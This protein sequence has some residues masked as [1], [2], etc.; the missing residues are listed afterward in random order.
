MGAAQP[1]LSPP[2]RRATPTP[3]M[4]SR[5]SAARRALGRAHP[6]EASGR[7]SSTRPRSCS[8]SLQD[9]RGWREGRA[10]RRRDRFCFTVGRWE[11][12]ASCGQQRLGLAEVH[13][14]SENQGQGTT[15]RGRAC[16]RI[17]ESSRF[18][19][20]WRLFRIQT[21]TTCARLP[22]GL[23]GPQPNETDFRP[24]RSPQ[25]TF[26]N[27]LGGFASANVANVANVGPNPHPGRPLRGEVR[28]RSWMT[29]SPIGK[30]H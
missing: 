10:G 26:T 5:R 29:I 24:T 20:P 23:G 4:S 30:T 9:S 8:A 12:P 15:P 13:A 3:S 28:A 21:R 7:R 6:M 19:D 27:E 14:C 18:P 16:V 17:S 2:R 1:R 11:P 25:T 22:G